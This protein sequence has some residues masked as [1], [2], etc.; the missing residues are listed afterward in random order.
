MA[1]Q[2]P[3]TPADKHLGSRISFLRR[4]RQLTP[5]QLGRKINATLQQVERYETGMDR[6][7]VPVLE[8]IGEA[9]DCRVP[10]RLIRRI[11][12]FRKLEAETNTEQE[13]LMDF[14]SQ[15]FD[16]ENTDDDEDED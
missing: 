16:E 13:E 5:L 2:K 15:V 3:G 4:K 9:M 12:F 7:P 10:K 14:Y 6:V 8:K 11:V 1:R